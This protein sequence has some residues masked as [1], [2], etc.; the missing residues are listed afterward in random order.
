M[1]NS[2]DSDSPANPAPK[3]VNLYFC[4]EK[5]CFRVS[6]LS[7]V[8]IETSIRLAN[9]K[10]I[11]SLIIVLFGSSSQIMAQEVPVVSNQQILFSSISELVTN[12]MPETLKNTPLAVF[13]PEATD[14]SLE[15]L[16]SELFDSGLSISRDY[17]GSHQFRVVVDTRNE[18]IRIS[19]DTYSRSIIG[20]I[21]VS[22]YDS[23]ETL[24]WSDTSPIRLI[25]SIN[26][27]QTGNL[28][29]DWSLTEFDL[30]EHRRSD[31]KVLNWI[32]PLV[33]T[34]AVATTIVLLF[35]IRSQ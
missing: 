10:I 22:V 34:G 13:L 35:S 17:T 31:R 28:T 6:I 1:D 5:L 14:Q 30:V 20:T 12:S 8:L 2:A 25:D 29:T 18:L 15:L 3:I 32:K 27:A 11:I 23:N 9:L 33:L 21:A 4:K 24:V 16:R 7:R 19:R 26:R